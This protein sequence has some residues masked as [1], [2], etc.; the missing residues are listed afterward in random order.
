MY[1][2]GKLAADAWSKETKLDVIGK[3]YDYCKDS[4]QNIAE[5]KFDEGLISLGFTYDSR[6]DEVC[7]EFKKYQETIEFSPVNQKDVEYSGGLRGQTAQ[8]AP[9]GATLNC[10]VLSTSYTTSSKQR[11]LDWMYSRIRY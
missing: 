5:T 8:H 3:M 9:P 1:D 4:K 7:I 6:W 10:Q 2:F 11:C